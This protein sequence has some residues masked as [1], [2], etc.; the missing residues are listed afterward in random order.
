MMLRFL[1]T[2]LV[3]GAVMFLTQC[4]TTSQQAS[5]TTSS[6]ADAEDTVIDG[7]TRP[8]RTYQ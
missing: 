6:G 4:C 2:G 5:S 7:L 8:R 3:T 1:F